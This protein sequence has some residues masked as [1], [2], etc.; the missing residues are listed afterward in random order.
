VPPHEHVRASATVRRP[1]EEVYAFWHN[2]TNLPSFMGGLES[3]VLTDD[4]RSRWKARS[5]LGGEMEWDALVVEDIPNE[6]IAWA[7]VNESDVETAGSVRFAPAPGGRG[8]EIELDMEYASSPA[9]VVAVAKMLG[10]EPSVQV[11]DDLRRFKQVMETGEV[12]RS[13]GTPEG[14]FTPRLLRQRPAQPPENV[15]ELIGGRT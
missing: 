9:P 12:V 13:D 10:E 3:V 4:T 2:F 15:G 7:S 14:P 1:L 8:T 5:P 11:K 6:L